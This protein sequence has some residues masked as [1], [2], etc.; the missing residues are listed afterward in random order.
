M[1]SGGTRAR[2]C[3]SVSAPHSRIPGHSN[4]WDAHGDHEDELYLSSEASP[5]EK[6]YKCVNCGKAYVWSYTLKRHML[7]EC[8]KEAQ[9]QCPLCDYKSKQKSNLLRHVRCS[10]N[11]H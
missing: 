11:V 5:Q 3:L 8:G 7:Y 6:K 1:M 2:D 9:F 4:D 10:H